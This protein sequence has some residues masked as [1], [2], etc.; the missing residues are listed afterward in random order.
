MMLI[1]EVAP[2]IRMMSADPLRS[3]LPP[4]RGIAPSVGIIVVTPSGEWWRARPLSTR[5][6][7]EQG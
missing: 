4:P 3:V 5:G 7:Y 6:R 1:V 2:P